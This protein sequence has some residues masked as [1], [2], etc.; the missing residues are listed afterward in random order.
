MRPRDGNEPGGSSPQ[1]E[2][3]D[4]DLVA[5]LLDGKER[6]DGGVL[7]RELKSDDE[8]RERLAGYSDFLASCRAELGDAEHGN[9]EFSADSAGKV[10][11]EGLSQLQQAI[12]SQTTREDVSWRGDLRLVG[13]FLRHRLHASVILRVVA[14]SLLIHIAALPVLAYFGWVQP[15]PRT[16][17]GFEFP[18]EL[19]YGSTEPELLKRL[20][21]NSEPFDESALDFLAEPTAA[22]LFQRHLERHGI[23]D[24]EDS[25]DERSLAATVWQDDL[26]LVLR[27]EQLLDESD[28]R[29]TEFS[30]N[31][32]RQLS[33]ALSALW[34]ELQSNETKSDAWRK[35]AASSMLRALSAERF[36]A[37]TEL[38][39]RCRSWMGQ[40]AEAVGHLRGENW[41]ALYER[42][43]PEFTRD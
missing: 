20:P 33:A 27:C 1:H 43:E 13:S 22:E 39:Q 24:F 4:E 5:Y 3:R 30:E 25:S 38:E 17:I 18:G 6:P 42:V 28:A 41:Q 14:A 35:L 21:E 11:S 7:G 32:G 8:L 15:E 40:G 2:W 29:G 36:P 12:L 19:P 10:D 16:R 37:S 23:H 34:V 31:R 26:G 9:S